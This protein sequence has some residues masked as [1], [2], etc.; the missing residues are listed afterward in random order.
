MKSSLNHPPPYVKRQIADS[1]KNNT[2]EKEIVWTYLLA[3]KYEKDHGALADKLCGE[4]KLMPENSIIWLEAPLQPTRQKEGV[5]WKTRAD[6]AMGHLE[7][8][9][10]TKC[11]VQATSGEWVCIAESKWHH[12]IRPK[13]TSK[14]G[15]N[16]LLRIIE[17]SLFLHDKKGNFPEKV[18]VT[19][20]TPR[21]FKESLGKHSDRDYYDKFA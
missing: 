3:R 10:G 14:T 12:D 13:S 15:I 18:Y 2:M 9:P 21:Y 8:V 6:L 1:I 20:V 16:Q 11:Q 7:K 19:L 4:D 5:S 17:H